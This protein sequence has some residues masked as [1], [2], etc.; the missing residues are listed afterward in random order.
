MCLF[1]CLVVGPYVR[2]V[3]CDELGALKS[4][5]RNSEPLEDFGGY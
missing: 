5:T 3:F 1:D 4:C 2:R